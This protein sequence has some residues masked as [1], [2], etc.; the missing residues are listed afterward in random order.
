MTENPGFQISLD[1]KGRPCVVIGGGEEAAEKAERLVESGAKVTVISPSLHATLRKLTASGKILHR[2]RAF[3]GGDVEGTLLVLNTIRDDPAFSRSL[4]EMAR[5]EGFLLWSMDQPDASTVRM[6]AVVSR[7]HLRVAIATSGVAPAFARR[8][9]EELEK[10]FDDEAS[11]FLGWLADLRETTLQQV[12]DP[13]QRRE[14]LRKAVEGF[15]VVGHIEYPKAWRE[16]Q[17]Q[18]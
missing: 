17:G 18:S 6:P 11:R 7:G 15:R 2:A 3:R 10:L 8:L 9:R 12:S 14:R 4:H 1:V 16:D 13:E 5:K